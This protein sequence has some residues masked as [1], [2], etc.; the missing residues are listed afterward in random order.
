M[1]FFPLRKCPSLKCKMG[2]RKTFQ[3]VTSNL[4][5][6]KSKVLYNPG[7]TGKMENLRGKRNVLSGPALIE[8]LEARIF[9]RQSRKLMDWKL[10]KGKKK[11]QLMS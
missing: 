8:G 9:R 6:E 4:Q 3:M 2:S 11:K 10:F 5:R 7:K 1:Y